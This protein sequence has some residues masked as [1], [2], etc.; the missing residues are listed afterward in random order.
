MK[1]ERRIPE[2]GSL[3]RFFSEQWDTLQEAF[4]SWWEASEVDDRNAEAVK[5][6]VEDIVDGTNARVRIVNNYHERLRNSAHRLLEHVE[7]MVAGLPDPL[8]INR[9]SFSQDP[10]VNAFF[11]NPD[12]IRQQIGRNRKLQRFFAAPAAMNLDYVWFALYMTRDEKSVLGSALS[13]DR[14]MREVQQTTISFS[15]HQAFA[16][17]G[18]EV[19]SRKALEK[20]LFDRAVSTAKRRLLPKH[21]GPDQAPSRG[22]PA[23]RRDPR[24]YLDELTGML[25][26]VESLIRFERSTLAISKLGIKLEP[27]AT[28]ASNVIDID[29]LKLG[30]ATGTVVVPARY[31]RSEME[32]PED[33]LRHARLLLG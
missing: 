21:A 16:L 17:R 9:H 24:D 2:A 4:D 1:T 20:R 12:H 22:V 19:E 14:I 31:P 10:R 13:G 23:P 25:E 32:A 27:G 26:D 6:A 18:D 11:V 5:V 30:Q 33:T 7:A 3:R 15:A 29:E 28:A 8:D